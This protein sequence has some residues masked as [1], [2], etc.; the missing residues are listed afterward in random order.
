[1]APLDHA[2]ASAATPTC[3]RVVPSGTWRIALMNSKAGLECLLG[4]L[5][6]S[7]V[8]AARPHAKGLEVD[9][10]AALLTRAPLS[11]EHPDNLLTDVSQDQQSSNPHSKTPPRGFIRLSS[12]AE[13]GQ[14]RER[15][16]SRMPPF[17]IVIPHGVSKPPA[18][19]RPGLMVQRRRGNQQ[20][21]CRPVCLE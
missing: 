5:D 7:A 20:S 4:L 17:P 10:P 1:M 14:H 19:R 3:D 2:S 16:S 6:A 15:Q 13:Q 12:H 21:N 8:L 18:V 9:Q 11:A